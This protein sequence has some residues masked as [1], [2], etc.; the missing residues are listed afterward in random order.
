M[1][2]RNPGGFSRITMIQQLFL[3]PFVQRRMAASHLG[4]IL[5]HF[6]LD[7]RARGYAV[8]TLQAYVQVAEHFSRWLGGRRL[9]VSAIDERTVDRFVRGHLPRCRCLIPAARS[10]RACQPALGCLVRF[11]RDQKL[12][13]T[14]SPQRSFRD[15]LVEDYDQH[16]RDVAGLAAATR[17][18]R[19][20]YA[21]EFLEAMG[22]GSAVSLASVR[23][24]DVVRYVEDATRRLKPASVTVL[25]VSVR[26]FLRFLAIGRGVDPSLSAAVPH[27]A[28]WPLATLPRV[29]SKAEVGALF[30]AFDRGSA[31]GRRDLAIATLMADL[32]LRCQEV[33]SL[34]LGDLDVQQCAIRLR[35]TKQRRERRVPWTPNVARALSAYLRRGRLPS[36]SDSVFVRHRALRGSPMRVHHVRAAMRMAFARAGIPSGKIHILRHTLATRL[37]STG[38]DLK[39][40]ADLLGHQSLDTTA[41]Y[42]RVD[43]EQ[44]RQAVLPWPGGAR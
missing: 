30:S 44:L 13:S 15:W 34:T 21:F 29:L 37:H 14:P 6:A 5:E 8:S 31:V 24:R 38:V 4:I 1:F 43:I 20:R 40:V 25:A 39:K 17:L 22:C 23:R 12:A 42:A 11:L 7:L 36:S 16:L 33:A 18:Y 3:R 9:G 2:T 19:R 41:R 26:D 28:P 27:P 10:E 35:Q 32:G